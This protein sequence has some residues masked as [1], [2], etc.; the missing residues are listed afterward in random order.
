MFTVRHMDT[1]TLK[2]AIAVSALDLG[3]CLPDPARRD[4]TAVPTGY[5]HID[6]A[7]ACGNEQE[8][9]ELFTARAWPATTCS[10]SLAINE[11]L[12]RPVGQL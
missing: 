9:G 10:P 3:G 6:T 5:R 4:R 12:L 8:V 1:L 2:S 11:V 7:A